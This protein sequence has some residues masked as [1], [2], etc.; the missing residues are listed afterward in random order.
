MIQI[1]IIKILGEIQIIALKTSLTMDYKKHKTKEGNIIQI[2]KRDQ[3]IKKIEG[4]ETRT[5]VST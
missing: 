5:I 3:A 2:T 4:K 1:K